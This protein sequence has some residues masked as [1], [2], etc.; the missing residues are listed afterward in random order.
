MQKLIWLLLTLTIY[1]GASMAA[2]PLNI[3]TLAGQIAGAWADESADI[4]VY[5]GIPYARPPVGEL[6]WVAP[7]AALP[8]QGVRQATAP[9][10]A[11]W[12]IMDTEQFVWS[13]GHFERSEDCLYL[14]IWTTSEQQSLPVMVWF[15]GGSHTSGMGHD[16]IFDGTNL[17]RQG[18][19]LVSVNYRLGPFG[20]LA[21]PAL[22]EESSHNSAGNYGLLDKL[23]ALNWVRDN[24]AQFGGNPENVTIFGQS[25]GSQS[26]C[27]LMASP[28]SRGLFHK[29]IGQSA[30]CTQPSA[31]KDATGLE[32]GVRL[33]TALSETATLKTLRDAS[34]Q[35]IM[36]A[37]QKSRW[38]AQSRIVVDGWVVPEQIDTIFAEGRQAKVPLLLGSLS[39]EGHLL[40][41]LNTDLD[42]DG[43]SQYAEKMAGKHAAT[44]LTLYADEASQSAGL[45]QREIATDLFM[46]YGMRRWADHQAASGAATYLYH[47]DHT[48]PA[49]RLYVPSNPDLQL[50]EGPRSAGAYHSADLAYVFGNVDKV[51]LDWQAAD[52]QL[53]STI[54][55]FWTNF[56]KSGNP[57]LPETPGLPAWQQYN[58]ETH[59]TLL[60]R[61]SP[62]TVNGVRSAKLDLWDQVFSPD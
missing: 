37:A 10:P 43:L 17:A 45:A 2:D 7:Q 42:Q 32:R 12:Q 51:G 40:F 58:T 56:A 1:S 21:H 60:L 22:A 49:F 25:A 20:F 5:R 41:P 28:L 19:V 57:N 46:A 34:P 61:E 26:V 48:P 36:Q 27:A 8:W 14:N 9:G 13:R 47:F 50:P 30:S 53:S 6:R 23:A 16:T 39:N 62:H 59:A 18:V 3:K 55:R 4:S 33:A 24:I 44:L 15:H 52:R 35:A 38:A 29:A 31:D 54:V 11:C